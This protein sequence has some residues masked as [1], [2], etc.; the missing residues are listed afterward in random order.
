MIDRRTKA[1][2]DAWADFIS[3][4]GDRTII[5][6]DEYEEAVAMRNVVHST[7]AAKRLFD[8]TTPEVPLFWT[9]DITGV[10]CKCRCDLIG[11]GIVVDYKTCTDASTD[12]FTREALRY[13]YDLQAAMYS[14]GAIANGYGPDVEWYFIA[15]EKSPPYAVNVIRAGDTFLERGYWRMNDLL[16]RYAECSRDDS[17]PGYNATAEPNE[18]IL[19]EWALIPED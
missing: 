5:T 11:K 2:R 16:A 7:L 3:K 14:S 13:G 15:Q 9:D 4:I 18:I 19:P 1:G 8:I 17:W 6:V 10:E 12:A